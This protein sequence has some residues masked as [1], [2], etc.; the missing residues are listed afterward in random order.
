MN[1]MTMPVAVP[2][3]P[4]TIHR[5]HDE[6]PFVELRPG[7]HAQLVHVNLDTGLWVIRNRVEP[8]VRSQ[9]HRHLGTVYAFTIA[10]NWRY[11]EYP[12]I[13]GPGSYLFEP[14]GSI[15]TQ[16]VLDTNTGLTDIWF[17]VFGDNE[18]IDEEGNV[19][20]RYGAGVMLERYLGKCEA[21]GLP[22]PNIVAG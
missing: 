18:D 5:A 17:A 7:L 9:R 11:L 19:I 22:R 14:A 21:A 16:Y 8:G 15:H 1:T 20:G 6:I 2:G 13:C 4:A 3:V 10:G 12:D